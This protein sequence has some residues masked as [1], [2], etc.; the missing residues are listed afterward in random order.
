MCVNLNS[1]LSWSTRAGVDREATSTQLGEIIGGS[2][3]MIARFCSSTSI[4]AMPAPAIADPPPLE[5]SSER[6]RDQ[7]AL[8]R[9][10]DRH[11]VVFAVLAARAESDVESGLD[12]GLLQRAAESRAGRFSLRTL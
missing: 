2:R 5:K 6:A 4:R 7:L 10:R 8:R 11:G 1:Q 3:S 9:R 12:D